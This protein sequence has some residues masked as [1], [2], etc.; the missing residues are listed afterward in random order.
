MT[1]IQLLMRNWLDAV[2]R[3]PARAWC[4]VAASDVVIRLPFAPPGIPNELHGSQALES[5]SSTWLAIEQFLWHDVQI[6]RT[7]DRE[8]I[9]TTARSQVKLHSGRHYE[10]SYVMLTRIR[11]GLIRDHTEYFNPLPIIEAFQ[12]GGAQPPI[13]AATIPAS[14]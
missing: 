12:L 6:R 5:L 13:R 9:V 7:E 10:N 14:S 4:A 3:G 8:L 11:D 1:D 2:A